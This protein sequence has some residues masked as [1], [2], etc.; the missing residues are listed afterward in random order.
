[1][2]ISSLI[3][4]AKPEQTQHVVHRLRALEQTEVAK[5]QEPN[6]VVITDTQQRSQDKMLWKQIESL[7]GVISCDLIY[8][9]FEDEED[10]A[11]G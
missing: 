6:I 11:N 5:V 10:F 1:M 3:I 8:H 2:P 9:N 7:P 4:T